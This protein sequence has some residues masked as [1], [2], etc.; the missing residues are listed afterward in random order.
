MIEIKDQYFHLSTAH[1]SYVMKVL[2][3]G[4]LVNVVYARKLESLEG[5]DLVSEPY[6]FQM[7]ACVY[8]SEEFPAYFQEKALFEYPAPGTGD[9]R[10]SALVAEYEEG[11]SVL[12]L[13]YEGYEVVRGQCGPFPA[14]ALADESVETLLVTLRDAVLPV[15]AVL[16]YAVYEEEDVIL[17]SVSVI[18][19][20]GKD[21][22]LRSAASLSLDLCHDDYTLLSYDGAHLRE[23]KEHRRPLLPGITVID[24]KLGVSSNEHNP[25][26]FLERE[27]TGEVY[28]FNL[29]YSGSH[30]ET[31][32]VSPFGKTRVITGINPACFSWTLAPGASFDTP[33]AVMT[34]SADGLGRASTAFHRFVSRY[35]VRGFWKDRERPVLVNN[36]E[37]TYFDFTEDKLMEI[38]RTAAG[39]GFEL[40]VLDD[41]W[42]GSRRDD[43][44][45]LGDWY[46][47]KE[48]FP[49]GLG[50]FADKVR[51]LGLGFG[52]WIEPEM[53]NRDSDLYRA[54]PDWVLAVP[55]RTPAV[56]RSQYVLDL[57]RKEVVD[58]IFSA[59]AEVFREVRP[60]Y[61]KWDMN[62]PLTDVRSAAWQNQ[63]ETQH[64]YV[65]GLYSLLER[66]TGAFP[67]ILFEGCASG[68]NRYDLGMFC[69]VPQ[70]WCSD[71]TDSYHRMSIQHGTLRGY[72]QSTMGAHVSDVP[73]H[74]SLRTTGIEAR[75]DVAAFGALGYEM[76]IS[77][78]SE[79]DKASVKAQI[80]FY[81]RYRDV[82]QFGTFRVL[83]DDGNLTWWSVEKDGVTLVL[84]FQSRNRPN[85]G[86]ADVLRVPFLKKDRLYRVRNRVTHITK[87][88]LGA[89]YHGYGMEESERYDVTVSG[90]ILSSCGIALPGQFM[91]T[92]LAPGMR[93]LGDNGTRLYVVEE[94]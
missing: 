25:L 50:S 82:F 5:I 17:R 27:S 11:L 21:L 10:E 69:Y 78:L 73:A 7:S 94:L 29:I 51:S 76:D 55:G 63:G 24:S 91:G 31:V 47:N 84:E 67:E 92:G 36:W 54:H 87:E 18:N 28:G 74:Q 32:E 9:Y 30:R 19:G 68:G 60:V 66:L 71:N 4:Q 65:L 14:H 79:A 83:G 38:A 26:I 57:S 34:Y 89:A 72:P 62:R 33:E 22:L 44:R 40:F 46:V 85:T 15:K 93:A 6:G 37:A 20:T 59:L 90:S 49:E 80:K 2:E 77:R 61:I 1:S 48:L 75:F 12:S 13:L 8:L 23:R 39:L 3:T 58:Y 52:L 45:G 64:R 35:I 81:K 43:T 70:F 86:S 88:S 42:F 56:C 16:R 41:G 53:V